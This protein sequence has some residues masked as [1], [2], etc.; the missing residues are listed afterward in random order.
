[1]TCQ[2]AAGRTPGFGRLTSGADRTTLA[3]SPSGWAATRAAVELVGD[4]LS[5]LSPSHPQPSGAER[6]DGPLAFSSLMIS[7]A[8]SADTSPLFEQSTY[9]GGTSG[10]TG[11]TGNAPGP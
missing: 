8:S 5:P 3:D 7:K 10:A 11:G 9:G 2:R 1:M 6:S 4:K